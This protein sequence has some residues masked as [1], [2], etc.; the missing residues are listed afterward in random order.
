MTDTPPTHRKRAPGAGRKPKEN[1][2]HLL[3]IRC[4][5]EEYDRIRNYFKTPEERA[6]ELLILTFPTTEK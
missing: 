5:Q 6:H 4:T 2:R 3:P 1:K